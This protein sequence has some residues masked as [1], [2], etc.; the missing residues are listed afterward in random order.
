MV[1]FRKLEHLDE[2]TLDHEV[3]ELVHQKLQHTETYL[4]ELQKAGHRD[5]DAVAEV[6]RTLHEA[7]HDG[8]QSSV[9]KGNEENFSKILRNI[10]EANREL[11]LKMWERK[12][13]I[14]GNL[15]Y[16]QPA[17]PDEFKNVTAAAEYADQWKSSQRNTRRTYP[18]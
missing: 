3:S 8:I 15:H 18:Q 5:A 16:R 11:A 7:A 9:E 12:G 10:E 1:T 4:E 17:L 2:E 13:F 6:Q 14:E